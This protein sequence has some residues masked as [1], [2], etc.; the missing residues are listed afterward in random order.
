MRT[1]WLVSEIT[2]FQEQAMKHLQQQLIDFRN[3]I[4]ELFPNRRD[5][6]FE[7]M[8][9]NSASNGNAQSV[10]QLS[11]SPF[12]KREYPSIT[13]AISNGLKDAKWTDIEK[14]L[15]HF[16]RPEKTNYHRFIVDCTPNDRIYA[17]TLE[18]RSIVHKPNPAPGNKPICAGHDYSVVA[19]APEGSSEERKR[20]LVPSST[21][22]VPSDQ[23]GHEFGMTQLA[24]VIANLDLE[25]EMCKLNSQ[26]RVW[27]IPLGDK[28]SLRNLRGIKINY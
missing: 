21:K 20:W 18:D 23:K 12:F 22:R 16:G 17:K 9:A 15:S 6:I 2:H 27:H 4:Y 8:D 13:D 11:K 24:D 5:S 19:Y 26:I 25:D 1:K 10:V 14:T 28:N 3:S 7:L